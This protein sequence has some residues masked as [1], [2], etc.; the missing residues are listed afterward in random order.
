MVNDN[1]RQKS[2]SNYLNNKLSANNR[3][4]DLKTKSNLFIARDE[5]QFLSKLHRSTINNQ[6]LNNDNITECSKEFGQLNNIDHYKNLNE[7]TVIDTFRYIFDKFKKGIFVKIKNNKIE[8]F[9]P[10]SNIYYRN[11]WSDKIKF[12]DTNSPKMIEKWLTEEFYKHTN[13]KFSREKDSIN[14][15]EWYANNCLLRFDKTSGYISDRDTNIPNLH[16]M[17]IS[18]CNTYN[19]PDMEFFMNKRDFPLLKANL[20]EPYNHIWDSSN[21]SLVSHKYSKYCP[22]ISMS[23]TDEYSDILFPTYE[24]WARVRSRDNITFPD[25]SSSYSDNIF[26]IGRAHV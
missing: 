15:T 2:K 22:I 3:Y 5:E 4:K 10:F 18:L 6:S 1:S 11:E 13:Y 19:I 17:L 14:I 26:K 25:T 24:D 9:L 20:T 7:G 21:K 23:K 8:L 16:D 12:P